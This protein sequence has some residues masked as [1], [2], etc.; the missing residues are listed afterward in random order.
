M[1]GNHVSSA[2]T[3]HVVGGQHMPVLTDSKER[4]ESYNKGNYLL[5]R[6][7]FNMGVVPRDDRTFKPEIIDGGFECFLVRASA[8]NMDDRRVFGEKNSSLGQIWGD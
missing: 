7:K 4:G 3:G 2:P 5:I 8:T 6:I 1:S